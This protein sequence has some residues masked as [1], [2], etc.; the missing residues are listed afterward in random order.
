MK[1]ILRKPDWLKSQKLGRKRTVEISKIMTENNL[2]TICE[3]AKCP[4][5]GECFEKGRAVFLILGNACTR[6]CKF[7]AVK[8]RKNL[9]KPDSDEPKRVAEMAKKLGLNHIIIT[10][11]TRDDLSDGG[12]SQF[13]KTIRE[14]RK[15]LGNKIYIEVLTPDFGGSKEAIKS[16]INENPTIFDHNL[17]TVKRL[18]K[19]V[20][21]QANYYRSLSILKFVKKKNPDIFTKTG[22]MVGLGETN[23][24]VI[25]LLE[26][27][28][29]NF[30]DIISIGQYLKSAK[31][32]LPVKEYILPKVFENYKNVA[33]EMGFF[34][35]ESAPLVRSSY[36]TIDLKEILKNKR[37]VI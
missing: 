33:T 32:N 20:R 25:D 35:V 29:K 9:P 27:A 21:P 11:V 15:K 2:H 4:N 14:L 30:V 8:T 31:E 23:E 17:E 6:N 37:E 13:V 36:Y 12:A 7:C 3:S 28:K 22:I 24:E 19:N 26:D 16:I 34:Y 1:S 10:S 18:Y 5:K